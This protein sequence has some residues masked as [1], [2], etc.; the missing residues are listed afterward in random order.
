MLPKHL[1]SSFKPFPQRQPVASR[2]VQRSKALELLWQGPFDERRLLKL[3]ADFI[4]ANIG[5]G[6]RGNGLVLLRHLAAS[7]SSNAPQRRD[8]GATIKS[9]RIAVTF[10]AVIF[11]SGA[12]QDLLVVADS[13][14]VFEAMWK[15]YLAHL[16]GTGPAHGIY[17][18][19]GAF[20][21]RW[22]E[23]DSL[24]TWID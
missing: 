14:D 21:V 24:Y 15:A 9:Y 2:G 20:V 4:D 1:P 22:T 17:T 16:N 18:V 23:V 11:K 10:E 8:A 7:L 5:G 3:A 12:V 13:T 6:D 19:N